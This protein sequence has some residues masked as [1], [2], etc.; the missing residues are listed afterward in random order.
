[1]GTLGGSWGGAAGLD[2]RGGGGGGP[3]GTGLRLGGAGGA[4]TL[5]SPVK[6]GGTPNRPRG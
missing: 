2:V 6:G 3:P 1:L 5:R 4:E